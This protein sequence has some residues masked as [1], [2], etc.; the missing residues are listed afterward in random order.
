M[1]DVPNWDDE[2]EVEV[3]TGVFGAWGN[4]PG[5]RLSG[6][7]NAIDQKGGVDLNGKVVPVV[8]F[9]L[10]EDFINYKERGTIRETVPAGDF[11]RLTISQAQL[12]S[13][14]K[15]TTPRVGDAMLIELAK[16]E[17]RPGGKTLKVFKVKHKAVVRTNSEEA[18]W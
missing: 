18:P 8:E 12:Q 13:A 15:A 16:V 17:P 4:S 9:E 14:F 2:P 7:I 1:T 3:Q 11:L 6:R 10:L 5:Q